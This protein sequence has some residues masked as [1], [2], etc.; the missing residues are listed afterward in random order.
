MSVPPIHGGVP[1]LGAMRAAQRAKEEA[2][3]VP[4]YDEGL[5]DFDFTFQIGVPISLVPPPDGAQLREALDLAARQ[6]ANDGWT[7]NTV[8][9][10][11][12][13]GQQPTHADEEGNPVAGLAAFQLTVEIFHQQHTPAEAF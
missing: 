10:V 8:R 6:L 5:F 13:L 1:D 9:S 2:G 11:V 12:H 4:N 7:I 3:P